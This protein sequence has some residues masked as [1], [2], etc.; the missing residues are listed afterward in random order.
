MQTLQLFVRVT[1]RLIC[2]LFTPVHLGLNQTISSYFDLANLRPPTAH[3]TY[4]QQT[5]ITLLKIHYL[6]LTPQST[7]AQVTR[8][9]LRAFLQ[10]NH[11]KPFASLKAATDHIQIARLEQLQVESTTR[12]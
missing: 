6:R 12:Q 4:T 10:G 8:P 3:Y 5:V 9:R 7:E 11:N 2:C 1:Q